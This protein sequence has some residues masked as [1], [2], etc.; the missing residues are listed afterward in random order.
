MGAILRFSGGIMRIRMVLGA[1]WKN[2]IEQ[3]LAGGILD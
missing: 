1:V 3:P 2:W